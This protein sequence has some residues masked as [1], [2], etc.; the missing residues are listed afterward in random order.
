MLA[1][2][3]KLPKKDNSYKVEFSSLTRGEL[4]ALE[5]ALR[6][7]ALKSPVGADVFTYLCNAMERAQVPAA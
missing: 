6:D 3:K 7:Y 2:V 1:S 5:N 4:L